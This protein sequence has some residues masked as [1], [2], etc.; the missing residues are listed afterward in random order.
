MWRF[1]RLACLV[2]CVLLLPVAAYAQASITGVVRD[3]SG[4]VLPG[5]TVE[6]SS[7]ALIEKVR[8][9][10]TDGGGQ[11]RFVDLR[12]GTYTVTLR[13]VRL[14][15][16]QAR[17]HRADRHASPP[18]STPTC[19][20]VRSQ[21]TITVTG[22]TPIVDVQS[23]TQQRVFTQEVIEAIP[24]GRSHINQTGADPGPG[25]QPAGSR[26]PAGR[27]RH[28]QPAEHDVHDPRQPAGR[29]AP[30]AR[31]RARRQHAVRGS[32]LELRARHRQHAGGDDRLRGRVGRAALRRAC[33]STSI[34]RE[35][36]NSFRGTVFATGVNSAWQGSNLTDEL[37]AARPARAERDE[38]GLRHQPVDRR[39]DCPR[40]AVVLRLGALAGQPELRGRP[41]RQPQRRRPDQ[42]GA[43]PGPQPARRVPRDA[44]GRATPRL[45][46]QAAQ[47]HKFSVFY[48][49]QSRDL[50]RQPCDHLAGVDGGLPLPGAATWRRWA[51]R[52]R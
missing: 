14:Q 38:A 22:E 33:A 21:E 7:P 9:V 26:R 45:T 17:R 27:G 25:G 8:S 47:K 37:Q 12:P 34:P 30:S 35:G 4:A 29:H 43:R 16:R 50:G 42:V 1:S 36:G 18:P 28:E 2:T 46:W 41:L 5:V 3:T 20:S 19:A 31:R 11:Y 52:R 6:A 40:P 39:P 13:P 49:N 32:V 10:V 44:E 15:H 51:G 23:A 24:A 48:D